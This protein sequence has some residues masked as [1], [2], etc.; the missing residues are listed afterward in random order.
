[1]QHGFDFFGTVHAN[2]AEKRNAFA[3]FL[4]NFGNIMCHVCLTVHNK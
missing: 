2:K 1:M 3:V 4:H